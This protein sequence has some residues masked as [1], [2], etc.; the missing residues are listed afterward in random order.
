MLQ[1]GFG[2]EFALD[3]KGAYIGPL[4]RNCGHSHRKNIGS[5][6]AKDRLSCMAA[7]PQPMNEWIAEAI[8]GG[9]PGSSAPP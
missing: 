3:P 8:I 7:Y 1:R 9:V 4:P 6:A 2:G 5:D